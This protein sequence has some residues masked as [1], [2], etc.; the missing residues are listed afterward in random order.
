M[1]T[2]KSILTESNQMDRFSGAKSKGKRSKAEEKKI[3]T[4]DSNIFFKFSYKDWEFEA[5]VHAAAQEFDRRPDMKESDW[6]DFHKKVY[7]KLETMQKKN[8]EFIFFSKKYQQA[9]VAAVNFNNNSVR[10]ITILPKGRSNPKPG[11]VRFIIE[12]KVYTD[13]EVVECE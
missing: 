6:K 12:G 8:G 4:S 3:A 9:Y 10:V 7:D 11:T 5:T 2:I 13:L 1:R